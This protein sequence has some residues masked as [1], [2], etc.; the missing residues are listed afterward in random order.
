MPDSFSSGVASGFDFSSL[1]FLTG[2]RRLKDRRWLLIP[3]SRSASDELTPADINAAFPSEYATARVCT[4]SS[5]ADS[6]TSTTSAIL[7]LLDMSMSV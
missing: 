5:F 3:S 7:C 1:G 4:E 2:Y 6:S